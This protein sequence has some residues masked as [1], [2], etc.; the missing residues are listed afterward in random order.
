MYEDINLDPI[1]KAKL[2][3]RFHK[4]R[5]LD[6]SFIITQYPDNVINISWRI[7]DDLALF[8]QVQEI[9]Q[10]E[11][12][13]TIFISHPQIQRYEGIWNVSAPNIDEK[14][15][16]A[17]YF[18]LQA[19]GP[20]KR[21]RY[22]WFAS[23]L[24][25]DYDNIRMNNVARAPWDF[26]EA[27]EDTAAELVSNFDWVMESGTWTQADN[28]GPDGTGDNT[29]QSPGAG[30]FELFIFG[31]SW[32]SDMILQCQM[33]IE[34][35]DTDGGIAFRVKDSDNYYVAH[36]SASADL[37]R[38]TRVVNGTPDP[39]KDINLTIDVEIYYTIKI[40]TAGNNIKVYVDGILY[41]DY[42]DNTF[43]SGRSGFW[44]TNSSV[45]F[46][47]NL[48]YQIKKPVH[49]G[50]WERHSWGNDQSNLSCH[51]RSTGQISA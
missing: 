4:T 5:L 3:R 45:I 10:N 41:I 25:S 39:L 31:P 47:D 16:N 17:W 50:H 6:G 42:Y 34:T 22:H 15:Y 7:I 46:F 18:N 23:E 20:S 2:G 27:D 12:F 8:R 49:I 37:V 51:F 13:A 1:D 26:E 40:E 28:E 43:K 30:N 48:Y 36:I 32:I 24:F 21:W 11:K 29:I 14:G 35:G 9:T 38:L 44:A 19:E 33:K